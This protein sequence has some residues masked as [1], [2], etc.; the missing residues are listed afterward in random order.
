MSNYKKTKK[1]KGKKK[2]VIIKLTIKKQG[3]KK[4]SKKYIA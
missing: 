3:T 4:V 1:L 2:K